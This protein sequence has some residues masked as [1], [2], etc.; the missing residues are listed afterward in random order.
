MYEC[1]QVAGGNYQS[2]GSAFWLGFW[3][4]QL[5]QPQRSGIAARLCP[6]P[7]KRRAVTGVR[8]TTFTRPHCPHSCLAPPAS[9]CRRGYRSTAA[10]QMWQ[11]SYTAFAG[12]ALFG[13]CFRAWELAAIGALAAGSCMY[14]LISAPVD[15]R[16]TLY[17]PYLIVPGAGPRLPG[18]L[19]QR[20]ASST[21]CFIETFAA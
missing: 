3:S 19:I 18:H 7:K 13:S 14:M 17:T 21:A 15:H 10:V 8:Q 20:R 5:V 6:P 2:A 1:M 11:T 16:D 9:S 4:L 12:Y